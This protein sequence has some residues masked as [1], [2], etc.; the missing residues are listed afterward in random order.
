MIR[1]INGKNSSLN[2]EHLNVGDIVIFKADN[3]DVLAVQNFFREVL[4]FKV[5]DSISEISK[6]YRKDTAKF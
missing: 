4:F 1:K 5:F 6:R 3:A 2:V